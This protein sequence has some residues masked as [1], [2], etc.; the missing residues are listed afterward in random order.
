MN[1]KIIKFTLF[2]LICSLTTTNVYLKNENVEFNTPKEQPEPNN[3]I[4]LKIIA[5][6]SATIAILILFMK[7][8]EELGKERLKKLS[9]CGKINRL[10]KDLEFKTERLIEARNILSRLE[11]NILDG[12]KIPT[13]EEIKK[14]GSAYEE[15][16]Q[17]LQ[18]HS[19]AQQQ[20]KNRELQNEITILYTKA[21]DLSKEFDH[22][23]YKNIQQLLVR[24]K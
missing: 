4:A 14:I 11:D 9:K 7:Q 5:A 22:S 13:S 15:L 1:N 21:E 16:F 17:E 23:E 3:N 10:K 18:A 20:D 19:N 8:K 6:G 12:K 24:T 2:T